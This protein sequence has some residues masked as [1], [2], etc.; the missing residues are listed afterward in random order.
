MRS[1]RRLG[2]D[3]A[4]ARGR[5][6]RALRGGRAAPAALAVYESVL[7]ALKQGRSWAVTDPELQ[8]VDAVLRDLEIEDLAFRDLAQLSGGQRQLVFIA[9]TLARNADIPLLDEPTRALD[10]QRQFEVLSLVRRIARARQV[11]VPVSIHDLDQAL[12]F[13]DRVLALARGR[14]VACGAPATPCAC[15]SPSRVD[16]RAGG[17]RVLAGQP[18]PQRPL[19]V[20]SR[21]GRVRVHG[22]ALHQDDGAEA[23]NL[24]SAGRA[25]LGDAD[26]EE[27]RGGAFGRGHALRQAESAGPGGGGPGDLGAGVSH[28][29]AC[30]HDIALRRS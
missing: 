5:Q 14:L 28:P 10:L 26:D 19:A 6:G 8:R 4:A 24:P 2:A 7:L 15:A 20:P 25:R 12:R 11:C 27:M 3:D 18:V 30:G 21:R 16:G 17:L 29:F 1:G 13:A 9:Q 22:L 23:P